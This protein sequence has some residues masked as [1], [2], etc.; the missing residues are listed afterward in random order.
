MTVNR[1][2]GTPHLF[3]ELHGIQVVAGSNPTTPTNERRLFG[4]LLPLRLDNY[5]DR[6]LGIGDEMEA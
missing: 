4:C 5:L 3:Y 2:R 6:I 1:N